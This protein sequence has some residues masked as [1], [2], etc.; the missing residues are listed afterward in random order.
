M[1]TTTKARHGDPGAARMTTEGDK[2]GEHVLKG[3]HDESG[4]KTL[5]GMEAKDSQTIVALQSPVT[6]TRP[7]RR[8]LEEHVPKPCT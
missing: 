8:D 1:A 6:V 5:H 7:V 2:V 3:D 4:N